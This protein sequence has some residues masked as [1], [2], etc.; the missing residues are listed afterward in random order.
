[1]NIADFN[2]KYISNRDILYVPIISSINRSTN[3]YQLD[4]DGNVARFVTFFGKNMT[5]RHLTIWLPSNNDGKFSILEGF[6]KRV[7][8]EKVTLKF[9]DD[10]G[11]HAGEQRNTS[12]IIYKMYDH[13]K[14]EMSVR[15]VLFLESQGLIEHILR[16]DYTYDK[17]VYWC[18]VHKISNEKTRDFLE[19]YS[20]DLLFMKCD[21]TIVCSPTQKEQ[22]SSI[23]GEDKVLYYPEM[24]DLD[25]GI[26][27]GKYNA[28]NSV[29]TF[30]LERDLR[31][32]ATPYNGYIYYLPYRISDMGYKI[33]RVVDFI[34]N[35]DSKEVHVMYTDPNNSH[36]LDANIYRFNPTVHLH[37]I[38]SDRWIHLTMLK[39]PN[40]IVPYFEDLDFIN[41]AMLWEMLNNH[42]SLCKVVVT[43]EQWR[44]NPYGLKSNPRFFYID[45]DNNIKRD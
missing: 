39:Q 16:Y 26:F 44:L 20:N 45:K 7:G 30:K 3:K 21:A 31:V 23:V 42:R 15:D 24:I 29:E 28:Q 35:D 27:D 10:F 1:M 36:L 12:Q 6:I 33:D 40:V 34:N 32:Y 18:P 37:H 17:L 13:L 4:C 38:S 43:E 9:V 41:H 11:K 8:K 5:F 25:M 2:R 14:E 22:V 19:G